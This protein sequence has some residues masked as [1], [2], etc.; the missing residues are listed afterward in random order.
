MCTLAYERVLGGLGDDRI[1]NSILA[2]VLLV[3]TVATALI[4]ADY[5]SVS[6]FDCASN[7]IEVRARNNR[8]DWPR[9]DRFGDCFLASSFGLVGMTTAVKQLK[10]VVLYSGSNLQKSSHQTDMN[11]AKRATV[12]VG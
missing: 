5:R 11:E 8:G 4:K 7:P 10:Q 2:G 6:Q 1:A 3:G 12:Y 9:S